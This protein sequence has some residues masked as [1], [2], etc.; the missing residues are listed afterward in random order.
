MFGARRAFLEF[1]TYLMA[2]GVITVMVGSLPKGVPCLNKVHPWSASLGTS[3]AETVS[4]LAVFLL[5]F[6]HYCSISTGALSKSILNS[7][8]SRPFL[9]VFGAGHRKQ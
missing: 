9:Q 1:E 6:A 5:D 3:G 2:L 4:P 7:A 8:L